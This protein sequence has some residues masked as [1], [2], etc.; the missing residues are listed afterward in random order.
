MR[1]WCSGLASAGRPIFT[2]LSYR[3]AET[4][5]SLL[6]LPSVCVSPTWCCLADRYDVTQAN[7]GDQGYVGYRVNSTVKAHQAY[8]AGV[9]HNFVADSVRVKTAISVPAGLESS[10]VSPLAVYLNGKGTVEHIINAEGPQT[11]PS[12]G[13]GKPA[14]WCPSREQSE[15]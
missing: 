9:Y 4:G 15:P 2:S 13:G 11:D 6:Q 7:F 5:D 12:Q 8:G 3:R 1:I 14:W 10:F